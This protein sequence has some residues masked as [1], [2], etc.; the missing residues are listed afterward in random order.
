MKEQSL[1]NSIITSVPFGKCPNQALLLL[2]SRYAIKA[3]FCKCS[4]EYVFK[5]YQEL[6]CLALTDMALFCPYLAPG[7]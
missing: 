5:L 1:L 2:T 7:F 4:S 6:K 3:W